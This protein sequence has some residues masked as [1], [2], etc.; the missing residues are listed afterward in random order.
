MFGIKMLVVHGRLY[1]YLPYSKK[2]M[3]DNAWG[4]IRGTN[5]DGEV[6]EITSWKLPFPAAERYRTHRWAPIA[7]V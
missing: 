1:T 4:M 7:Q 2:A 3:Q 5:A 6:S